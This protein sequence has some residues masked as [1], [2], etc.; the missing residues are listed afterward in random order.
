MLY[1][2]A[3]FLFSFLFTV[4]AD[5]NQRRHNQNN[6]I[7]MG[8]LGEKNV[9]LSCK[10]YITT[11]IVQMISC[12]TNIIQKNTRT[13]SNKQKSKLT[14]HLALHDDIMACNCFRR[15]WTFDHWWIPTINGLLR[16]VV[17]FSLMCAWTNGWSN[18]RISGE[19]MCVCVGGVGWGY[20]LFSIVENLKAI[21][22]C[23]F[24]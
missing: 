22:K 8:Y 18:S 3:V 23:N 16:G 20:C 1:P 4:N 17:M 21:R 19:L 7:K 2:A 6:N 13:K 5:H 12:V 11:I 14:K 24:P 10:V 15:N 9:F